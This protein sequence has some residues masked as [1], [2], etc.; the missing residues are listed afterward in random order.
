MACRGV[1]FALTGSQDR[2]LV[3]AP[4]DAE[5]RAL[6]TDLEA[7]WDWDFLC[8]ADKAWDAL[9]RCLGDGTL[10]FGKHGGVLALTVL[11][12]GLHHDG[13]DYIVARVRADQVPAVAAALA[14][15]D[16]SWLRE[17]YDE[18]DPEDYQGVLDDED[19]RYTWQYLQD[20]RE[21]YRRAADAGRSVIFTVDQ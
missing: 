20:A 2:E 14:A 19:F 5:V 11:G 21:F 6:V 9:H 1:W 18:I 10:R 17:R 4:G 8:E 13:P 15:V 7:A 3:E 16:E 12:G